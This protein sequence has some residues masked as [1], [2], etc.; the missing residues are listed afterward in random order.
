M[1]YITHNAHNILKIVKLTFGFEYLI[2]KC[3]K[4]NIRVYFFQNIIL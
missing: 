3:Y 4:F 1:K 2:F